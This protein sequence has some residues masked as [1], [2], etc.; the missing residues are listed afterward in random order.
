VCALSGDPLANG[1]HLPDG[2]G[3]WCGTERRRR[4]SAAPR[5]SGPVL[6]H[7]ANAMIASTA[8]LRIGAV[9]AHR[10]ELALRLL[11]TDQLDVPALGRAAAHA[12]AAQTPCAEEAIR[13]ICAKPARQSLKNL[14]IETLDVFCMSRVEPNVPIDESVG[15]NG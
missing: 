12:T 10:D 6:L 11:V 13:A 14:G 2:I 4:P 8:P 7:S 1:G 9:T 3:N 5:H 15:R